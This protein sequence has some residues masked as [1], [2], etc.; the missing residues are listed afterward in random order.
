MQRYNLPSEAPDLHGIPLLPGE[1]VL[2]TFGA[3]REASKGQQRLALTGHRLMLFT[4]RD[5][6]RETTLAALGTIQTA[7]V[8][9]SGRSS[10]SLIQGIALIITGLVAYLLIGTF[11]VEGILVPVIVGGIIGII[12]LFMVS[13]YLFWEDEG[14]VTFQGAGWSASFPCQSKQREELARFLDTFFRAKL[15]IQVEEPT[16]DEV[17]HPYSTYAER[18][19]EPVPEAQQITPQAPEAPVGQAPQEPPTSAGEEKPRPPSTDAQGGG[20]VQQ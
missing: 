7:T 16:P 10:K 11:V 1:K 18:A 20:N 17:F 19:A 13:H 15:N 2:A 14:S 5:G 9:M 3:D 8:K 12:G 6:Q 4:E